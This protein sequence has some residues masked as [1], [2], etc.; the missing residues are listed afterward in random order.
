MRFYIY[1]FIDVVAIV[2]TLALGEEPL[3]NSDLH[4]M[5]V[6]GAWMFSSSSLCGPAVT[7]LRL[8]RNS[9]LAWNGF[10]R[11]RALPSFSVDG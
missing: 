3:P 7:R 4:R 9:V 6:L 10:S 11:A 2:V 1:D 8:G 5:S